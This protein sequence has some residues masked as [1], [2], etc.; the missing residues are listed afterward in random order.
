MN[1]ASVS[2]VICCL[3]LI[4][5]SSTAIDD[6]EF[7]IEEHEQVPVPTVSVDQKL[8]NDSSSRIFG[9]ECYISNQAYPNEYLYMV[10][11]WKGDYPLMQPGLPRR[12]FDQWNWRGMWLI[13]EV[14]INGEP[15]Y[16]F[17]NH[18][19]HKYLSFNPGS[20]KYV[21]GKKDGSSLDSIWGVGQRGTAYS[22]HH[23]NGYLY[24]MTW[25]SKKDNRFVGVLNYN[26]D[27]EIYN[28]RINC[29]NSK[30]VVSS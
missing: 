26:P 3:L 28:W 23:S 17:W 6:F 5:K 14:T 30:G 10:S 24:A 20:S 15:F 2:K 9:L 13:N 21:K 22:I 11:G 27:K 19:Y 29:R 1:A 4:A 25:K 7:P 12:P 8:P 16:Q 18:H